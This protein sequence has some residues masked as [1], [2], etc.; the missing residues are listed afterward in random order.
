MADLD[1]YFAEYLRPRWITDLH[2]VE[3][4][5]ATGID[6]W[7]AKGEYNWISSAGGVATLQLSASSISLAEA[8]ASEVSRFSCAAYESLLDTAPAAHSLSALS[9]GLIRYYYAS[10]YAAH[11]LLR[12]SGESLTMISPKTAHAMNTAGGY[13]L[14]VSPNISSASTT[15]PSRIC[16]ISPES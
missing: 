7:L 12:V 16:V 15:T 11:A 10:F 6:G 2:K 5:S 14:G 8:F 1:T 3:R 9:W 4:G 13:Y